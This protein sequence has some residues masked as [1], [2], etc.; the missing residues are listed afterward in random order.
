M[1]TQVLS[2][3]LGNVL[4]SVRDRQARLGKNMPRADRVLWVGI[5][6]LMALGTVMVLS[7]S[8]MIAE[9]RF[10]E[11]GY[12]W[13][14]QLLWSVLAIIVMAIVSRIDYRLLRKWILPGALVSIILLIAVLFTEPV[15]DA[16]R[17]LNLGLFKLQPAEVFRV[18]A[19]MFAAALVA[20]R[21]D[22]MDRP[23]RLWPLGLL[24]IIGTVLFML[25]P[26]FSG[27][28]TMYLTIGI[29]LLAG[30]LR[31]RHILPAV[32]LIAIVGSVTVFGF[33]YKKT[34]INE[35]YEG[36]VTDTGG[37]YQVRQSKVAL[38]SGGPFGEGL[39]RGR[40]K[41]LYL[42]E[43][44]TDF[45]LA[46]IGEELGLVGFTAVV[47]LATLL[48]LR[49]WRVATRAPDRFGYLLVIGIGGALFVN[50]GLNAGVV[51][52]LVPATGLP[53][54]FVS[55]GGSS[56]LTTAAAWGIVLNVS[57]YRTPRSARL[58]GSG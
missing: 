3:G 7:S 39:G 26:E 45:V 55:Y 17:W 23:W 1:S 18:V 56:L 2:H 20:K 27:V 49:S 28:M 13:K 50:A 12:F 41:M 57:R 52:G 4:G 33:E 25:Q 29:I 15:N 54:P 6:L 14:K 43:P 10:G 5:I 46:T 11:A 21:A 37:S 22:D 42:P 40:A 9:R 31:W 38:G 24:L 16:K 34:R 51:T 48:I 32:A 30:G 19:L 44:H 35:W 8:V 53:F 58:V 47:A 36:F